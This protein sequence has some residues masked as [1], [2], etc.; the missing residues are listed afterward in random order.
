MLAG[1]RQ[2]SHETGAFDGG[3][4]FALA[5]GTI[6]AAFAGKNLPTVGQQLLQGLKILIV[7]VG[8]SFPAKTT[9]RLLANR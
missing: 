5:T 8:L 9:L 7:N 4:H 6:A 1:V 2:Q 3:F